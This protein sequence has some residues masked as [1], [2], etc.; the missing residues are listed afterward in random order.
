MAETLFVAHGCNCM[1]LG[2]QT[3]L[4][5]IV[6]AH[7]AH[8]ADIV[9]L[10]ISTAMPARARPV[11]PAGPAAGLAALGRAVGGDCPTALHRR[12]AEG[13]RLFARF[14]EIGPALAQWREAS[15]AVRTAT[16]AGPT[17]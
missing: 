9:A 2:P 14:A 10:S 3:P 5:D 17:G 4:Q 8:R 11:R 6:L 1:N 7:A 12:G 15:Q 13:V 16:Q